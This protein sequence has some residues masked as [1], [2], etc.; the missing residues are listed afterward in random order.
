MY[1]PSPERSVRKVCW[2]SPEAGRGR[3]L[4]ASLPCEPDSR[5]TPARALWECDLGPLGAVEVE[6]AVA[7]C[8]IRHSDLAMI[9]NEGG[10]SRYPFAPGLE[11]LSR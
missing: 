1:K 8:G 9:N 3:A 5:R 11:S 2:P 6:V 4:T 10:M 7:Y